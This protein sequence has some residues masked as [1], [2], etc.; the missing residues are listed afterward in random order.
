MFHAD[1][2]TAVTTLIVTYGRIANAPKNHLR[3]FKN[4]VSYSRKLL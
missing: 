1:R 3:R 4:Q 2:G